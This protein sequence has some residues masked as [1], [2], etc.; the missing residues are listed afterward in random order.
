M[1]NKKVVIT[2]GAGFIGSNIVQKLAKTNHCIVI[3]DLS[4][5][6]MANISAEV[7]NNGI[8]FIEGSIIDIELLQRTFKGVDYVLHQAAI[9]SVPRSFE[10]PVA[11]SMVNIIGTLN[12]L[13]AARD[14]GV[15][16]VVYASSSS[17]YGD[18]LELPKNERL[19]PNP[20][21]P[22]AIAKLAGERNCDVFS[23]V[24]R[25]ATVSLRYFNVYGP[26]QDPNSQYAAVI[27]RFM[28]RIINNEPP[29]IFGDGNQTRDFTFVKDVIEAVI[30]AAQSDA[31]GVFNIGT[32]HSVLIND[33]AAMIMDL[34]GNRIEPIH[35]DRRE[36][37]VR[38]SIADISKASAIGYKPKYSL[39]DGLRESLEHLMNVVG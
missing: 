21:S 17:V 26:R 15:K 38:H 7:E 14:N 35:L 20:L 27:P 29:I 12:V 19:K 39:I 8:E 2:G 22:Y 33:L 24:F 16:K 11:C 13:L 28:K 25:L 23:R 34:A 10:D 32:G 5:G 6:K 36:G 18:T 3:D 4:T 9:P 30:L 1:E 37:D 31:T